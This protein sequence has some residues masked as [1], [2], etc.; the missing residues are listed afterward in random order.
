[1]AKWSGKIGF[2]FLAETSPGIWEE[3]VIERQYYGDF[4]K[5]Y[6]KLENSSQINDSVNVSN[7][8]SFVSD[9]Y[10]FNN[11]F[12]IRYITFMGA[13]WRVSNIEVQYPRLIASLG[14]L[15]NEQN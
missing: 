9:P 7:E 3:Q 8:I 5:N 10:A 15:Y 1:M 14:D 4:I 12:K 11:F 13:K 6:R 2:V